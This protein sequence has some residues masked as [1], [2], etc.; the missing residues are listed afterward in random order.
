MQSAV[1]EYYCWELWW[2]IKTGL[3]EGVTEFKAN[4]ELEFN[5]EIFEIKVLQ[6]EDEIYTFVV[7]GSHVSVDSLNKL[8]CVNLEYQIKAKSFYILN[9]QDFR[10][11]RRGT[12]L[13]NISKPC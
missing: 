9:L 2:G 11:D 12:K 7:Y 13:E 1:A 10:I 4:S 5:D 6:K 8:I 3:T